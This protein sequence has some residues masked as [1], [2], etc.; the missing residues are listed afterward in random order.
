MSDIA[1]S[2]T[3]SPVVID[4][5]DE[6]VVD[7]V[8]DVLPS[9]E[10]ERAAPPLSARQHSKRPLEVRGSES[11]ESFDVRPQPDESVDKMPSPFSP[12]RK[13]PE[14]VHLE[15]DN[16]DVVEVA[17]PVGFSAQVL[18]PGALQDPPRLRYHDTPVVGWSSKP[19][20]L[21]G[22]G[23]PVLEAA[24]CQVWGGKKGVEDCSE[25]GECTRLQFVPP[26]AYN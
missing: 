5:S 21:M 15:G 24:G 7:S 6:D 10:P 11:D 1:G 26:P 9:W 16:G 22:D 23:A 8:E 2:S 20:V 18:P 13:R 3:E 14:V 4:D 12:S 19:D 25:P 17:P